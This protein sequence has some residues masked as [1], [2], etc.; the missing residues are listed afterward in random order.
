MVTHHPQK[1]VELYREDEAFVVLVDLPGFDR[2][3]VEL[4]WRDRRLHVEA[5][6]REPGERTKVFH[7]SLG[8]PRPVR[9]D[10]ITATLADG[11]LEVRLP[12]ADRERDG[13]RIDIG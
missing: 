11:V 2:E 9:D 6:H 7:R 10:E 5:I 3:D 8:L 4:R 1:G 13:R 12:I